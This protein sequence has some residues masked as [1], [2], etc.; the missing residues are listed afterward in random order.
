MKHYGFGKYV[1]ALAIIFVLFVLNNRGIK[2]NPY[3]NTRKNLK[4]IDTYDK[5]TCLGDSNVDIP[6]KLW[7]V[8]KDSKDLL[9]GTDAAAHFGTLLQFYRDCRLS[10]DSND[11]DFA[12]PYE[13]ITVSLVDKF[14]RFGYKVEHRFGE[15]GTP[16]FE[17]SVRHPDGVKVDLFGQVVEP[18]Y[19]WC[20]LWVSGKLRHC[21]YPTSQLGTLVIAGGEEV[22]V[23]KPIEPILAS[24]YGQQW[25]E[26]IPTKRWNWVNPVCT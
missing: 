25:R 7:T 9:A 15:M 6:Q 14:T 17:I 13:Q 19:S 1:L 26:P 8:Y 16:G 22:R 23:R 18:Y 20:P 12:L 10:P 21:R 24:I 3:V 4:H 11:I 2:E 5:L